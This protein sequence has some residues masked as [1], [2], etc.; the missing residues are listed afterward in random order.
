MNNNR[1]NVGV[2]RATKEVVIEVQKGLILEVIK[3]NDEDLYVKI[4]KANECEEQPEIDGHH[5]YNVGESTRYIFSTGS[6]VFRL[7]WYNLGESKIFFKISRIVNI[8]LKDGK[9]KKVFHLFVFLI[10]LLS[11]IR[12]RGRVVIK[13]FKWYYFISIENCKG[14]LYYGKI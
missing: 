14:D 5:G 8:N 4:R 12:S 10:I 2:T 13:L 11:S 7:P 9:S 1:E 3:E 6:F